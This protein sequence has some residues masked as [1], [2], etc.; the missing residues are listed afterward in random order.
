MA[1]LVVIHTES[2]LCGRECSTRE[3]H[4][5]GSLS[6]SVADQL[7]PPSVSQGRAKD[8]GLDQT[9]IFSLSWIYPLIALRD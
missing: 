3:R 4:L 1:V 5:I 8:A 9:G 7:F 2:Q 6:S